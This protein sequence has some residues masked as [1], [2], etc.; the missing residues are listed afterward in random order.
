M[1]GGTQCRWRRARCFRFSRT[2]DAGVGQVPQ[3]PVAPLSNSVWSA[4]DVARVLGN[5]EEQ[6]CVCRIELYPFLAKQHR[7]GGMCADK[8]TTQPEVPRFESEQLLRSPVSGEPDGQGKCFKDAY[9]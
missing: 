3:Q 4:A 2:D 7:R 6:R 8:V 5:G 1:S 9:P